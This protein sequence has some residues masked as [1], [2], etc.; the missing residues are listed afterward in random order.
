VQQELTN[1]QLI[2]AL[3]QADEIS[4]AYIYQQY[5]QAVFKNINKLIINQQ[6]AEDILQEVFI[7]L[8]QKKQELTEELSVAGWLFTTSYYKSLEQLKKAVKLSI[9]ELT[10]AHSELHTE[11][12]EQLTNEVEYNQKVITLT[13]AIEQLPPQKKL[14]FKLCRLEGKTYEE[15]ASILNISVDT[16]K[17]YVKSAS[18]LLRQTV[19][20]HQLATTTFGLIAL[21]IFLE[22]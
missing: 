9:Y 19:A 5:H 17:E 12:L 22:N 6:E 3:H 18:K 2:K 14:A 4:F 16:A 15:I 11:P 21:S 13:N 1:K 8:W 10:E 20:T 7:T